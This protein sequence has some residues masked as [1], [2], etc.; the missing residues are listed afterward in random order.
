[1]KLYVLC[2]VALLA[3][4]IGCADAQDSQS[5]LEQSNDSVSNSESQPQPR[6]VP[7]KQCEADEEFK[8]CGPCYQLTC[9]GSVIDCGGQ[10]FA[11]CYCAQGFVREYPDGRCIPELLFSVT[12]SAISTMKVFVVALLGL[13]LFA[14][15]AFTDESGESTPEKSSEEVKCE[16]EKCNGAYEEFKCCGKCYQKTCIT[17]KMECEQKCTKGCFCIDGFIREYE[18]G[19]C[20][21]KRLCESFLRKGFSSG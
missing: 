8:C 7:T 9:F 18:G 16:A 11:E 6:C 1:M 15:V 5:D 12:C 10:C 20:M 14:G 13:V 2:C 19:K 21:P 3:T 17:R 4:V